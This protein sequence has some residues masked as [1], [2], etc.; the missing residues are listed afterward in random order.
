MEDMYLGRIRAGEGSSPEGCGRGASCS[1]SGVFYVGSDPSSVV[2]RLSDVRT[3]RR[4]AT[5]KKGPREIRGPNVAGA[6]IAFGSRLLIETCDSAS[7]AH[8]RDR[9]SEHS[10]PV[11]VGPSL[12][13]LADSCRRSSG[14]QV[15]IEPHQ[16]RIALRRPTPHSPWRI[17]SC[18][19]LS[20]G[21]FR[22]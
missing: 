1:A 14:G 19:G 21:D 7:I 16:I 13:G 15:Q 20:K 12:R 18:L 8:L 6:S 10:D 3:V 22:C 5:K 4:R 2:G 17:W 11:G 9:V